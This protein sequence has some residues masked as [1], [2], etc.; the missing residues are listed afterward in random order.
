[1]LMLCGTFI[2]L[3]FW[4]TKKQLPIPNL[5]SF[6]LWLIFGLILLEMV[7]LLESFRRNPRYLVMYLPLFYLLAA[8]VFFNF[9]LLLPRTTQYALRTTHYTFIALILLSFFT[10]IG[11]N[12]LRVAFLTPEPAYEAAFAYV[13]EAW[14]PGDALLTMNTPAAELYLG[15]V[16]GF[17]VQ[18]E[19]EQFLLNAGQNSV[20]RWVG[21]P[22][23]GNVAEFNAA[24]NEHERVWF[25]SD[26]IR[27]PVYFRGDWQALLNNQLEQVWAYDNTLVYRTRSDRTPLPSQPETLVNATLGDNIQLV[28][29]SLQWLDTPQLTLFWQTLTPLTTDYTVF[30]HLRDEAGGTVAQHDGL[31]VAGDYPTSRWQPGETIIDPINFPLP[32]D[33]PPGE[34]QFWGGLYRLDTLERLVVSHD[35]SGENAILLGEI[36]LP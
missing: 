17:T 29:Y 10:L 26:T 21:V 14:Q 31:P 4:L 13:N 34:Y 30:L 8:P 11:F 35:T 23:L 2:G 28:G 32:A 20:D 22:W 7:T 3:L 5:F 15:H 6:F 27:Q 9:L 36:T 12:D 33:L 18:N 24:L 19:A 16:D 1:M 25:V